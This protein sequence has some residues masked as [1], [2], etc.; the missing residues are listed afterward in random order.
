MKPPASHIDLLEQPLYAHL[1][2]VRPD[3]APQSSPMWFD[4]DGEHIR[5]TH[6]NKRQ[7]FRNL[8]RDPRIALSIVDPEDPLRSIE[9]RGVV[10][11]SDDDAEASFYQT[12]QHRY[13]RVYPIDDADVRIILS[14]EPT[15]YILVEG[16]SIVGVVS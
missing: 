13:G 10:T 15:K 5:M 3:G 14:I 4:W 9:V 2:T 11:I 12:L 8:E 16:G 1:A 6:S 7:K